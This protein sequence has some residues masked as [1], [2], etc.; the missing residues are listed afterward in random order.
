[1]FTKEL[2]DMS[3]Y[4]WF[5]ARHHAFVAEFGPGVKWSDCQ[6]VHMVRDLGEDSAAI[7]VEILNMASQ[8]GTNCLRLV[9]QACVGSHEGR[10]SYDEESDSFYLRL[11][12]GRSIDQK[13]VDG[14]VVQDDDGRILGIRA[15]WAPVLT[16]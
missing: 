12:A 15:E 13:S 7:G 5:D 2:H 6:R 10:Y 11:G 4:P 8:L 14:C 16:M 1:V 3:T 9:E